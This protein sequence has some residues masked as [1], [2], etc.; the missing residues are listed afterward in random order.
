MNYGGFQLAASKF[1]HQDPKN[2]YRFIETGLDLTS[3]QK[4]FYK[5]VKSLTNRSTSAVEL[6]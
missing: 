6:K 2:I 3:F 1:W 4:Y 5:E